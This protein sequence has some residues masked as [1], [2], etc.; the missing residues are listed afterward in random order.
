MAFGSLSDGSAPAAVWQSPHLTRPARLGVLI[1][2]GGTTLDNL[3]KR[4]E[5]GQLFATIETVVVSRDRVR[6]IEVAANHALSTKVIARKPYAD[7]VGKFSEAVFDAV[8]AADADLVCLAGFLCLLKIPEEFV[9]RVLNI[10]PSLL[11]KFGGP[12]M[13]GNKVHEAVIAA[14]ERESGCTVHLADDRYDTGP[15]LLQRSCP[16][17]PD[18]T[19][20]ELAA[21]VAE[22]ERDAY[23]EVISAWIEGRVRVVGERATID[24]PA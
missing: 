20:G 3:A 12:G 19:P 18:D 14:G 21:R 6:G 8:R 23:P 4:I 13:Y 2:G 24:A 11:P 9:N 10:H 16:V 1:S 17:L 22:Q 15:I 7:E 5:R